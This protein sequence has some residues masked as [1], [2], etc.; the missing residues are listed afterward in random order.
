M[1][2]RLYGE[3]AVKTRDLEQLHQPRAHA[4]KNHFAVLQGG[5]LFVERQDDPDRLRREVLHF[6]KVQHELAA[7]L[8]V[9]QP[10]ELGADFFEDDR[11][12][13]RGGAELDDRIL[14]KWVYSEVGAHAVDGLAQI[15]VTEAAYDTNVII[16]DLGTLA[17][18]DAWALQEQVHAQVAGGGE[19]TILLVEHPPVITTGRRAGQEKHILGSASLLHQA[20]V[21]L[22]ESDRGG[23]VTFH[24]P[25]QLVAYPIIR[26]NDHRLSV[27]GYV[28]RLEE[29]VIATLTD[30]GVAAGKDACA[31][32][33]WA[34]DGGRLAKICAIG[35]RIRRGVSMHG[36]ALNVTTDLDYFNLIVPCGLI[37]RP[38]TSIARLLDGRVPSMANVKSAFGIKALAMFA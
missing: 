36:L 35:V 21:E 32:G 34:N 30:L 15:S 5:Q 33:V 11:V 28:R 7:V 8:V 17:Y 2:R 29:I 10:I 1:L 24:G 27:G 22:V 38:V 4:A 18:R 3:D 13:Q 16:R 12:H 6:F 25:G 19:E 20:G 9:H 26:L 37:G 23:D 31:I 14:V